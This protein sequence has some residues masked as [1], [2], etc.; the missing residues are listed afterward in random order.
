[1]RK[2]ARVNQRIRWLFVVPLVAVIWTP[3]YAQGGPALG[4]F[5][6]VIWYQFAMVV[7]G[8]LLT[9]VVY[10]IERERSSA[11]DPD[12]AVDLPPADLSRRA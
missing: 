7:F 1:L 2:D 4:P 3:F 8:S 9:V 11:P 10:R 6:F 12:P 5:P